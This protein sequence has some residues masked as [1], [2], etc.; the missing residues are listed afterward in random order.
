MLKQKTPLFLSIK[1][2]NNDLK[3]LFV[4]SPSL[5]QAGS[6]L[7]ATENETTW[8]GAFPPRWFYCSV[9]CTVLLQDTATC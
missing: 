1:R 5:E 9:T 7:A 8:G 3:C 2:K 4:A 6:D